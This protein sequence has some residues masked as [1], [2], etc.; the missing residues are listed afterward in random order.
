MLKRGTAN[1]MPLARADDH[2]IDDLL[3]NT[4]TREEMES[5]ADSSSGRGGINVP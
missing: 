2:Q 4:V 1:R 5:I 3:H